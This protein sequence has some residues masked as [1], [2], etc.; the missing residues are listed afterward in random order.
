MSAPRKDG[1]RQ[2][3]APASD[4][5][6]SGA[7]DALPLPAPASLFAN[8]LPLA[9]LFLAALILAHGGHLG[10]RPQALIH[11]YRAPRVRL[12]SPA[13]L[14]AHS[15]AGGGAL[16]IACLGYV[17]DVTAGAEYYGE[18]GDYA[19]FTGVDSSR[20]F[21]IGGIKDEDIKPDLAGL[22]PYQVADARGWLDFYRKE[23]KYVYVGKVVGHFWDGEGV[24]TARWGEVED[25]LREKAVL[26][27][28][29]AVFRSEFPSCKKGRDK[30]GGKAWCEKGDRD[31]VG[32]P[33][34]LEFVSPRGKT[35]TKCFCVKPQR[36][37]E[38]ADE[39]EKEVR[40][41]MSLYDGCAEDATLCYSYYN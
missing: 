40:S 28:K 6:P 23:A 30:V 21:A 26:E 17:F 24:A 25:A 20:V 12:V 14:A 38:P 37:L 19:A 39:E 36:W 41:R 27:E 16:W 5:P 11:S 13:E 1:L 22:T 15:A 18:G 3:R 8:S 7:T 4:Q 2:R 35:L 9:L 10:R 32:L 29:A 31:W 34:L 33:R